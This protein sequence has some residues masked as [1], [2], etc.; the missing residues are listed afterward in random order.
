M[1]PRSAEKRYVAADLRKTSLFAHSRRLVFALAILFGLLAVAILPARRHEADALLLARGDRIDA[2]ARSYAEQIVHPSFLAQIRPRIRPIDGHRLTDEALLDS[3]SA[4]SVDSA[5]LVH[6]TARA[7]SAQ[8]AEALANDI[9]V[10]FSV[11]V[12]QEAQQHEAFV[13][14]ELR[15]RVAQRTREIERL[16]A[17]GQSAVVSERLLELQAERKALVEQLASASVL[18]ARQSV[19]PMLVAA[20]QAALEPLLPRLLRRL[21]EGLLF[22]AVVG[23]VA[24]RLLGL[25]AGR[26]R[27]TRRVPIQDEAIVTPTSAS[28]DWQL[29][30]DLMPRRRTARPEPRSEPEPEP[31]SLPQPVA[32]GAA[33]P[34]RPIAAAPLMLVADPPL[35]PPAPATAPPPV[36][37]PVAVLPR[38]VDMLELAELERL[39]V[40]RPASDPYLQEERHALLV[41]LRGYTGLDGVIPTRFHPLVHESFGDLLGGGAAVGVQ[42]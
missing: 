25:R 40:A 29:F 4:Y 41:S 20:P 31:Q 3:V 37:A 24:L 32:R 30:D 27:R 19:G 14:D 39:V 9:A 28:L 35:S 6:V 33:P 23:L 12:K 10:A 42:A 18:G 38:A 16:R 15:S 26:E 17:G 7:D 11:A 22:G 21:F 5:G 8:G 2:L 34:P 36:H 13:R 1:R